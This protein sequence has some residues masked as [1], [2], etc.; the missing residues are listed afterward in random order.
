MYR[1]E[2]LKLHIRISN[3]VMER[4]RQI[5]VNQEMNKNNYFTYKEN[6]KSL[7]GIYKAT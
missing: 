3:S 5:P 6:Q 2:E 1:A 7:S 4:T